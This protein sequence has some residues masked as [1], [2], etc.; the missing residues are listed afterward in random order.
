MLI[1]DPS[2]RPSIKRILEKEFLKDRIGNLLVS[3]LSRHEL[4]EIKKMDS[5]KSDEIQ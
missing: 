2:K 3:T 1:K 4:Q 5:E